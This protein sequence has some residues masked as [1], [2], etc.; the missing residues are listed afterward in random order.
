LSFAP[1]VQRLSD[2]DRRIPQPEGDKP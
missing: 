2:Q 1:A